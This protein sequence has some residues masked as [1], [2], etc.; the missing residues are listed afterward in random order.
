L[1]GTL[2]TLAVLV[3]GARMLVHNRHS[4]Y[5]VVRTASVMFFQL[6]F[7]FTLPIVLA[8]LGAP[9]VDLKS[10]W[11]LDYS[12]FF[13][14][15]IDGLWSMGPVGWAVLV[16]SVAFSLLLVPLLAVFF[17]KRWYCSWV[18]GCGALAET[19]GDPFRHLSDKRL[20]A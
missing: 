3:M 10:A 8:A 12:L 4:R 11:P 15:R 19:V 14:W 5:Q 7:A 2:Y 17:G 13:G 18:C 20:A 16:W 1:Y 9:E 6:G